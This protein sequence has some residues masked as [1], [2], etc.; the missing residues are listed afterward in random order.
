MIDFLHDGKAHWSRGMTWSECGVLVAAADAFPRTAKATDPV[1]APC[2]VCSVARADYFA[3]LR[4]RSPI[5]AAID[6]IRSQMTPEDK[7]AVAKWN[8][9]MIEERG[10]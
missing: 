6:E 7:E 5:L 4:R 8:R 2:E 3:R 9:E 1:A 10:E